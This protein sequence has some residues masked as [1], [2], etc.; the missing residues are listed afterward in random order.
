MKGAV[1][2]IVKDQVELFDE[3]A[4]GKD[5]P[6]ALMVRL[7]NKRESGLYYAS[8]MMAD[9]NQALQD[10]QFGLATQLQRIADAVIKADRESVVP[11]VTLSRNGL[12]LQLVPR[13]AAD[14]RLLGMV[15]ELHEASR[16]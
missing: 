8:E 1:S 11:I 6:C 9:K 10:G 13:V 2:A 3:L 15:Q 5:E 7:T 4:C 14:R 16:G 12:R